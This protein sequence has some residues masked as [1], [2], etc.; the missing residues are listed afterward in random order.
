MG[1]KKN[2]CSSFHRTDASKQNE[3][4]TLNK[5]FLLLVTTETTFS[6]YL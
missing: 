2:A 4:P 5:F 3:K 1:N 6:H